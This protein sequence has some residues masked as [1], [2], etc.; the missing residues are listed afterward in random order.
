MPDT[1][2]HL[3]TIGCGDEIDRAFGGGAADGVVGVAPDIEGG[4][5]DRPERRADRAAGAIPGQR[6]FHRLLVAEHG[7]MP[8]DRVGGNAGRGQT[9]AQPLGVVGKNDIGRTGFEKGL[10]VPRPLRL[11]AAE[12]FARKL[13]L[14]PEG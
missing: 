11:I 4:D 6:G 3:E 13:T 14:L 8:R 5:A 7:K 10:V 9:L 12:S 1:R 2:K